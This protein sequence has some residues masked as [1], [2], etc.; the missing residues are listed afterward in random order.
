M[1][2]EWVIVP[3]PHEPS[4]RDALTRREDLKNPTFL[5]LLASM[6]GCVI[7]AFP[8][9]AR[10]Y[11]RAQNVGPV[12]FSPGLL[13]ERCHNTA[14]QAREA[15]YLERNFTVHDA[16]VS[17]LLGM[18]GSFTTIWHKARVYF[19]QSLTMSRIIGLHKAN[20][21]HYV[22][23]D[24]SISIAQTANDHDVLDS[25]GQPDFVMQELGRRTFW[26]TFVAVKSLQQL[27]MPSE[28]FNILPAGRS[29]PYPPLPIEVDDSYITPMRILQQP[30][31][32]ISELVGF[33]ANVRMYLSYNKLSILEISDYVDEVFNWKS[34]ER[35]IEQSLRTITKAVEDLPVD[36]KFTSHPR[37]ENSSPEPSYPSPLQGIPEPQQDD[38]F[39]NGHFQD[40]Y[41]ERRRTQ[42]G[43]QKADIAATQLLSRS[44]VVER[45]FSLVD[46]HG[47]KEVGAG[48][49]TSP[50]TKAATVFGP[51]RYIQP[52][53]SPDP[54]EQNMVNEQEEISRCLVALLGTFSQ[55]SMDYN[56]AGFVCIIS[57]TF[58]TTRTTHR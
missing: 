12:S 15:N 25:H 52:K 20:G 24:G 35:I 2:T 4:F 49:N 31:G 14:T 5:A 18:T 45:Y 3:V 11:L 33:N 34:Q 28:E 54:A 51:G 58:S 32:T 6:V 27:G 16:I 39:P 13:I 21:P 17:Y 23:S 46:A 53:D 37:P 30:Q 56:G 44:Y 47:S 26:L 57:S 7:A 40:P 1:L 10:R 41:T 42:L 8:R 43:V 50:G 36:L 19:E 55:Y 9:K 38:S 29:R 22:N 48:P